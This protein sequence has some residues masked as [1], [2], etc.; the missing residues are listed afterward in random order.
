MDQ[1]L[2]QRSRTC[3][4]QTEEAKCGKAQKPKTV[5]SVQVVRVLAG[6][7]R[8]LESWSHLWVSYVMDTIIISIFELRKIED[9]IGEW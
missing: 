2:L 6:L 9:K 1:A 3:E 8:E 7:K 5:W 4:L